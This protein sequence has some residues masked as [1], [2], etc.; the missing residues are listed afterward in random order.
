V[1]RS[2]WLA[3]VAVLSFGA[4]AQESGTKLG[5]VSVNALIQATP[6]GQ[7]VLEI[8][9]AASEELQPIQNQLETYNKQVQAG[10]LS[11]AARA[12]ANLLQLDYTQKIQEFQA[13]LDA[14]YSSFSQ[15]IDPAIAQSAKDQGFAV[16]MNSE[17]AASSGLV[18][19]ADLDTT[20]LTEDVKAKLQAK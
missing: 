19:Y 8:R 17:V 20:N 7:A 4:I 13:K 2:F 5:F 11:E 16:V 14:A 18:I 10:T 1:K 9:R 3:P 15:V 12:Q 6:E